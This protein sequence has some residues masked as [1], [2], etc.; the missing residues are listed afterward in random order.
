MTV[1]RK[2][3]PVFLILVAGL[4]GFQARSQNDDLTRAKSTLQQILKLF[5]AGHDNL[6]YE[7]FPY[8][9]G[10]KVTYLAGNDTI[11]GQRVAYLLAHFRSIFS[12]ECFIEIDW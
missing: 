4:Q 11:T 9:P 7:T 8:N 3:F 6:L 5:D 1:F 12:G 10:N 2:V